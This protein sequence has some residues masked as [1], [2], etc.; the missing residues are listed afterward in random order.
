MDEAPTG[1]ETEAEALK[2]LSDYLKPDRKAQEAYGL[3]DAEM[4][5]LFAAASSYLRSSDPI[6]AADA[7]RFLTFLNPD[8]ARYWMGLGQGL[9][10]AEQFT[11]SIEAYS[12]A[13]LKA[14]EDPRPH[15]HWATCLLALDRG[16]E[17]RDRLLLAQD[18][19]QSKPQFQSLH[20]ACWELIDDLAQFEGESDG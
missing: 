10:A 9:R 11:E 15:Y 6:E 1:R 17:A 18:Y 2:R 20:D 3:D 19:C 13:A 16:V 12:M 5:A 4:E 14:D 8:D 7:F